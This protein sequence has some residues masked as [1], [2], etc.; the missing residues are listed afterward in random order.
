[1]DII[2]MHFDFLIKFRPNDHFTLY[3]LINYLR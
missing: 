1:M 2:S 3:I